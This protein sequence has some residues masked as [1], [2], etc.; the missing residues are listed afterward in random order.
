MHFRDKVL[1]AFFKANLFKINT[2]FWKNLISIFV[3]EI[4]VG[5]Y[6]NHLPRFFES[7][8]YFFMQKNKPI[9]GRFIFRIKKGTCTTLLSLNYYSDTDLSTFLSTSQISVLKN[10]VY[11]RFF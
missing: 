1:T 11:M 4:K 5:G 8:S 10:L 2:I 7:L 9:C 3:P 6:Q